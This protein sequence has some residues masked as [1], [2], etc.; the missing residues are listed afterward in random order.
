[1]R[2]I[3]VKRLIELAILSVPKPYTE[4]IIED[5]FLAIER[6]EAWLIEYEGL[7]TDLTKTVVNNWVGVWVSKYVGRTGAQ[8]TTSSRSRLAGSYSKLT[9][10]GSKL[11]GKRKEAEALQL[12]SDYYQAHKATLPANIRDRRSSIVELLMEGIEPKDAFELAATH[13]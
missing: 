5:V 12:M 6:N 8:Q 3:G 4:D 9:T 7:C 2:T 10:A 13:D 11:G 1:M